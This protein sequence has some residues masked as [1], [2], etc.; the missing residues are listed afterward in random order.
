MPLMPIQA[1]VPIQATPSPLDVLANLDG[2]KKELLEQI[3]KLTPEQI[4]SFPPQEQGKFTKLN[5]PFY[6]S[7]ISFPVAQMI[8]LR[9]A[10]S[11][12]AYRL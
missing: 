6:L 12:F 10:M 11:S 9:Q 8:Q 2:E 1:T 5:T 3:M 4:E 7:K